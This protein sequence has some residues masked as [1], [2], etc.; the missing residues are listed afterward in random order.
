MLSTKDL[1]K[2]SRARLKDAEVL[3]TYRRFDGATYLCG[4]AVEISLKAR[5][6]RTLKWPSYPSTS[7]EFKDYQSFRTHDLDILLHLSGLEQSIKLNFFAEWS[8]VAQWNPSARYQPIGSAKRT[9]VKLMISAAKTL[10]GK[11]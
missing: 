11:I 9:D 4:Y 3:F 6:C 8:A 1:R 5:I 2:I 7:S 10:L